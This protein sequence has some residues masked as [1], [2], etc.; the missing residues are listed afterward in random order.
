M[1]WRELSP[2]PVRLECEGEYYADKQANNGE[3]DKA[4]NVVFFS[5]ISPINLKA[6]LKALRHLR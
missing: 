2:P 1:L 6:V 4:D 5:H 3:Y